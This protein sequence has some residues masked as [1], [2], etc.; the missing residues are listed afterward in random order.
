MNATICGNEQPMNTEALYRPCAHLGHLR[1]ERRDVRDR[2][3]MTRLLINHP[4]Q[5]LAKAGPKVQPDLSR[6]ALC[7]DVPCFSSLGMAAQQI[8]SSVRNDIEP[9]YSKVR[10]YRELH[11]A[12]VRKL[13]TT[14]V[15]PR[16]THRRSGVVDQLERTANLPI[17]ASRTQSASEKKPMN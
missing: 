4:L 17:R 10:L 2:K 7:L 11:K 13:D 6:F 1:T 16:C 12:L 5:E 8:H 9:G 14:L 15:C 3:P